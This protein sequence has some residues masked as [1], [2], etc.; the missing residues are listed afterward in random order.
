[1]KYLEEIRYPGA[2]VSLR[3]SDVYGTL[4]NDHGMTQIISRI[5]YHTMLRSYSISSVGRQ[6]L[7]VL[8]FELLRSK[9]GQFI[10]T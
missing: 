9:I 7:D 2:A 6:Q 1:M 10:G 8:D 4:T 5:M 3:V